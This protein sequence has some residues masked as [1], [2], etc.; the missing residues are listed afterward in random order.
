MKRGNKNFL[1]IP[2]FVLNIL[3]FSVVFISIFFWTLDINEKKESKLQTCSRYTIGTI[4]DIS[5]RAYKSA[6]W[7][8]VFTYSNQRVERAGRPNPINL[9]QWIFGSNNPWENNWK[10]HRIWVQVYC[11][12]PKFHRV[13]WDKEVP[14]SIRNIP[15]SGWEVIPI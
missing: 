13:L 10:G 1:G 6:D 9:H 5:K 11:N 7:V 12:D 8:Y 3:F 2:K 15:E 4:T 14:D